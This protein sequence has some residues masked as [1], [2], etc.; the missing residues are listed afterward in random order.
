MYQNLN[1]KCSLIQQFHA[2]KFTDGNNWK[3]VNIYYAKGKKVE[4]EPPLLNEWLDV[5]SRREACTKVYFQVSSLD[6]S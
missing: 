5:D 3:S 4:M 6:Q 1:Y 2:Y